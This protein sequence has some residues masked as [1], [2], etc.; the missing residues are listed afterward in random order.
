MTGIHTFYIEDL[1]KDYKQNF[2]LI[3]GHR[4]EIKLGKN[5]FFI[6]EEYFRFL[7]NVE[8][9]ISSNIC[10]KFIKDS[11]KVY[12]NHHIYDSPLVNFKKEQT[13]CSRLSKY[14]IIF[15]SSQNLIKLY[16][17]MFSRYNN[18]PKIKLPVLKEIGYPKFDFL[19][20]KIKNNS[21]HRKDSIL[22]SPVNIYG[23]PKF[24]LINGLKEL[25]DELI[26]KTDLNIIFRPHPSNRHDP[27]ILQIKSLFE[28]NIKFSYDISEDYSLVYS[29]SLCLLTDHS[30]TAYMFAFLTMRPVVFFSNKNL[31]NFINSKEKKT[32]LY[33]YR[34]L[35]Y[36][37]NREKIGIIVQQDASVSEKINKL[38]HEYKKYEISI[39]KLKND[40]KY[41][42]QSKKKFNDEIKS[43]IFNNQKSK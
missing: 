1:F 36:F 28:G 10:D 5:Y 2:F 41:L 32:N 13:L 27:K 12:L 18:S 31:D 43:L 19:E 8:I 25:I 35:N 17:E 40:I 39:S 16:N 3:Y 34:N 37:I 14:D 4:S 29:K 26:Y 9:F 38:R 24:S 23:D 15:L 21:T 33:N 20:K 22:I 42:G 30:D 7:L 6:K 11:K